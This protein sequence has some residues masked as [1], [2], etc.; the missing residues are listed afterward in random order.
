MRPHFDLA[1]LF[2]VAPSVDASDRVA[3]SAAPM[4]PAREI[5][6]EHAASAPATATNGVGPG[7]QDQSLGAPE[8]GQDDRSNGP[9]L[10]DHHPSA[11]TR[12]DQ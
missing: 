7:S 12:N 5:L 3:S 1:S 6:A 4:D 8:L 2:T 11:P 9:E 10:T